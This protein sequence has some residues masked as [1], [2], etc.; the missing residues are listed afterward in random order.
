MGK[1]E[2]K[3]L[4]VIHLESRLADNRSENP[5]ANMLKKIMGT[6]TP[7]ECPHSSLIETLAKE[8]HLLRQQVMSLKKHFY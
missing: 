4:R 1:K 7:A 8:L 6:A 2:N 5:Y 3:N